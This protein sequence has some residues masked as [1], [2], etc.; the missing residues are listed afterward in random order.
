MEIVLD[1]AL[2]RVHSK[3]KENGL[4]KQEKDYLEMMIKTDIYVVLLIIA[5][6]FIKVLKVIIKPIELIASLN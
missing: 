1:K 2:K 3:R 4:M 5:I 6:Q